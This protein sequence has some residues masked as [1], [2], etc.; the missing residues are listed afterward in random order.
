MEKFMKSRIKKESP[1]LIGYMIN[2]SNTELLT[3]LANSMKI[4]LKFIGRESA[5]D[6]IGFLAGFNGFTKCDNVPKN[7]IEDECL[8]MSGFSNKSMDK[9]LLEMKS[10]KMNFPLKCIVTQYNQSWTLN[11][12]I[13][14]L[15]KEHEKMKSK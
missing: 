3:K 2:E 10:Y 1:L 9:L 13:E 5:G 15:K 4:T 11:N 7:I 14:E 12:L 8:I 6:K